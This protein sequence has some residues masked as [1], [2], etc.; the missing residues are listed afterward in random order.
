MIILIH[1]PPPCH[2]GIF[3]PESPLNF[4]FHKW[5]YFSQRSHTL[6]I[7]NKSGQIVTQIQARVYD[8]IKQQQQKDGPDNALTR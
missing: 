4:V 2:I 1:G 7:I 6:K 3:S 8:E 5:S